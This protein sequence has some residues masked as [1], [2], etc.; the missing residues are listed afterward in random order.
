M[1]MLQKTSAPAPLPLPPKASGH[2]ELVSALVLSGHTKLAADHFLHRELP[3]PEVVA[4][5]LRELTLVVRRASCYWDERG[6]L[7]WLRSYDFLAQLYFNLIG[8][9]RKW[10][11]LDEEEVAASIRLLRETLKSWQEW[12]RKADPDL[13]VSR[14]VV[15]AL[16]SDMKKPMSV[17]YRPPGSMLSR[18]ADRIRERLDDRNLFES[19]LEAGREEFQS[20]I[21]YKLSFSG[22]GKFGNDY[23]LGLRWL[24]H[25]GFVQVST[26]P[27]L[28]AC[29]YEDEPALWE[30]F[31][32]E[33]FCP[34][35]K[36]A[37]AER[38]VKNPDELT[39]LATEVSV[40]PNLAVFR[41]IFIGSG[42]EHGM[43]SYQLNPFVAD[44][45]EASLRDALKIYSDATD[46][47]VKYDSYLLWGYS[48]SLERGRP[49]L[50]FKVA[51][52]SPASIRITA[53]LESLG[54]GTNNTETYSVSQETHLILAKMEGRAMA[55]RRGVKLT[56]VYETTMIGRLDDHLR[57][58]EAEILLRRALA[59][60]G[61]GA[62]NE[63][64][65]GLGV[66]V[67]GDESVEEK[68]E[69]A[70]DR[71]YLRP[72]HKEPFVKLLAKAG[73][74]G[75]SPAE[76]E[77]KLKVIDDDLT[78]V[79]ILVTKRVYRIFFSPENRKKW[80]SY[81]ARKYGLSEE[82][83]EE[84]L[85][86]IDMLPASKRKPRETLLTLSRQ[87]VTNTEFPNFQALVFE[88]SL[89]PNF[90]PMSFRESIAWEV[91]KEILRRLERYE[92]GEECR[93]VL[94][95][96]PGLIQVL[97][98]AGVEVDFGSGG[99]PPESWPAFGAVQKTRKEFKE[100]YESFK[101]KVLQKVG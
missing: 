96:T 8:V 32:G 40:F 73:V 61:E 18:M 100:A 37:R 27:V 74:L 50:V 84:V 58:V 82:Q 93:K 38:G 51:G 44:S 98:E 29:A 65:E 49:N 63:L 41:P 10:V 14:E 7:E 5:T 16:L 97:R 21:Y 2:A 19:F 4:Q 79:G 91:D 22:L 55:V 57:E 80:V 95:L 59:V 81:L 77:E 20:N 47:L 54:I 92:V 43:I 12:E 13:P 66:K 71:K 94:E 33:S 64:L 60:L 9:E 28:A 52:N 90:D 56:T 46:F 1:V 69:L 76:V 99:L 25:L 34:D 78:H 48:P 85:R 72:I 68:I 30:G 101:Q 36:T 53:E 67:K 62:L 39:M 11:G 83:A 75:N 15:E 88:E 31:S 70:C 24:R 87:H 6:I 45:V 26:N 3:L 35:L 42:Y 86:G 89:S 17:Y 23:A